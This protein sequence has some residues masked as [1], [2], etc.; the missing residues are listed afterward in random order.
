MSTTSSCSH[1]HHFYCHFHFVSTHQASLPYVKMDRA[2]VFRM[3]SHVFLNQTGAEHLVYYSHLPVTLWVFYSN[4]FFIFTCDT[5]RDL[6]GSYFVQK[7]FIDPQ[8]AGN[9]IFTFR[10]HYFSL[11]SRN[12]HVKVMSY[13]LSIV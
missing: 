8:F 12:F 4:H 2:T 13:V 5:K 7:L 6:Q 9:G 1:G 10:S 3:K 11:L